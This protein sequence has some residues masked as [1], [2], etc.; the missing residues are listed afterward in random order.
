VP[1]TDFALQSLRGHIGAA[2]GHIS[3]GT[4]IL[5]QTL[6]EKEH[7]PQAK[8][9]LDVPINPIISLDTLQVMFTRL[10]TQCTQLGVR[11]SQTKTTLG[12]LGTREPG[13][14]LEIPAEFSSLNEARNSI[15]FLWNDIIHYG[16]DLEVARV[17]V[18]ND[19]QEAQRQ[20]FIVRIN[21]WS[22]A[23]QNMLQRR[24][25]SLSLAEDQASKVLQVQQFSIV[26]VLAT[27]DLSDDMT[28]DQYTADF[29]AIVNLSA[30]VAANTA[31]SFSLNGSAVPTFSLDS[32]IVGP[33]FQTAFKC[34]CPALRRRAI[35]VLGATPR[36]E[37][38]WDGMLVARVCSRIVEIEE[39]GLGL[40]LS[41][42]DVPSTSRITNVDVKFDL[43]ERQAVMTYLR[44]QCAK[45]AAKNVR[46]IITW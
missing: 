30:E 8:P 41:C 42:S 12:Y 33:L 10:D 9:T 43:E 1:E 35:T 37:G 28:W 31:P 7:Q 44:A 39:E 25:S 13:F 36:Q 14:E 40:V 32:G 5:L 46:E 27:I 24:G 16:Y 11:H 4:K 3:S 17:S 15:D 29:E 19:I 22:A 2:L 34:R 26:L 20:A 38:V 6:S 21:H 23:L 45:A 18:L